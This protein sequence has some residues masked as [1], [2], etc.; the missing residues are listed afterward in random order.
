MTNSALVFY[1]MGLPAFSYAKIFAGGFYSMKE[2]KTPVKIAT[3]C[4]LLNVVL[5][6]I[7]MGPMGV[8]GLALATAVSSWTSAV[9]LFLSLRK[10]IGGL[11]GRKI[12]LSLIKII[13]ATSVMTVICYIL[14]TYLIKNLFLNVFGTIIVGLFLYLLTAKLLKWSMT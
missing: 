10:R 9:L 13:S 5:N 4:M 14:S 7:L 1:S 11:G 3:M 2:T 8:G 12:F 6:I